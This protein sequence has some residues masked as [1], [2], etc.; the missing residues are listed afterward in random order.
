M[1]L[2]NLL[3]NANVLLDNRALNNIFE[4]Y[5]ENRGS[6]KDITPL[7]KTLAVLCT[8][9]SNFL[10]EK[11]DA[12]I[13]SIVNWKKEEMKSDVENSMK[14][15]GKE[16]I[17]EYTSVLNQVL[18]QASEEKEP[19]KAMEILYLQLGKLI[20]DLPVDKNY[21]NDKIKSLIAG[22]KGVK[23]AIKNKDSE[24]LKNISRNNMGLPSWVEM[25][26]NYGNPEF[27]VKSIL[28][29]KLRTLGRMFVTKEGEIN[30]KELTKYA[31][32]NPEAYGEM[33]GYLRD[34]AS[35]SNQ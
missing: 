26:S 1:A 29:L 30:K 34:L 20:S 27:I 31:G 24:G 5:L 33:L 2:E 22:I 11:S 9:D 6:N 8:G 28:P 16:I 17:D 19:E 35:S 3:T 21:N 23:E 25:P 4:Q 18:S 13:S 7:Y 15:Y 10:N 12:G 32:K 14:T